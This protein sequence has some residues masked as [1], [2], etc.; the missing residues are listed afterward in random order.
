M[1]SMTKTQNEPPADFG[2][3]AEPPI[4][5][6]GTDTYTH[7][8]N[9]RRSRWTIAELLET[10]FPEPRWAVPGLIPIGLTILAGRP[11]VGKSWMALQL[12]AAV[13]IG[14][15]F[16]GKQVE[17][18]EVLYIALEDKGVRLKKRALK[19][20]ISGG[21]VTFET[22]WKPLHKGGLEDLWAE[23]EANNYSLIIIDTLERA[24]PGTDKSDERIMGPIFDKLQSWANGRN[25]AIIVI[26]HLRKPSTGFTADPINDVMGTTAKAG[27][28]DTILA[29]Y[30]EQ[31]KPG[32]FLKGRGRE[33]EDT[34]LQL[35]W[36]NMA[37]KWDSEG[38]AGAIV[39]TEKRNAV[40]DA[41]Q[42]LGK[43]QLGDI[44]SAIGEDRGNTF[45]RLA[46]MNQAGLVSR[47]KIGAKV[48]YDV[49]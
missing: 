9:G 31:G 19:Q 45:K 22:E 16:L 47:E 12:A 35:S 3:Y 25:L 21:N 6:A 30:K 2:L 44:A 23:F 26:D 43:S 8:G 7:S 27:T 5:Y 34:E 29:I 18:G 38:D 37:C 42:M 1:H 40:L 32:A 20:G 39:M 24:T 28:A 48:Y 36:D 13:G 46:D 14:G 10:D 4:S 17:P 15:T 49:L 41:L 11:K 33:T